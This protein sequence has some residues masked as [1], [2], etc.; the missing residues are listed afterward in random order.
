MLQNRRRSKIHKIVQTVRRTVLLNFLTYIP[1]GVAKLAS[2][3]FDRERESELE[4]C[5]TVEQMINN[6][7]VTV[8]TKVPI[9]FYDEEPEK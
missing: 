7:V 5:V 8:P 4:R 3:L 6:N 1:G 9:Y 2:R